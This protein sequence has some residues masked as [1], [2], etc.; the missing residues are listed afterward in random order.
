MNE[1]DQLA[2]STRRTFTLACFNFAMLLVLFGGLG[3]VIWQSATLIG[4]LQRDLDRAERAVAELRARVKEADVDAALA[5]VVANATANLKQSLARAVAGTEVAG[6][7]RNMSAKLETT[8]GKLDQTSASVRQLGEKLQS[9]DTER[10]AQ[11]ISYNMLKGL[12][13]G[14]ER[15]AEAGKPA[16]TE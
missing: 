16:G 13:R 7:L 5:K 9:L 10:L 12:G 6:S 3:Y 2:K 15:A 11:L 14:F 4:K 8:Q 1:L